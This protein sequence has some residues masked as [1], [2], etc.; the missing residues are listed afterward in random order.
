MERVPEHD[1]RN[2]AFPSIVHCALAIDDMSLTLTLKDGSCRRQ[3]LRFDPAQDLT[4]HRK[5]EGYFREVVDS[6]YLRT[7]AFDGSSL[8]YKQ[9][10][11]TLHDAFYRPNLRYFCFDNSIA[12]RDSLY[13]HMGSH[14]DTSRGIRR[15]EYFETRKEEKIYTG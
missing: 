13:A 7:C 14:N 2:R 1:T 15:R 4:K 3:K 6:L 12:A 11:R 9:F 10:R 5:R 8:V